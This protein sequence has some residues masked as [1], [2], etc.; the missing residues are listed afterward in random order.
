MLTTLYVA[1][2]AHRMN[3]SEFRSEQA[4]VPRDPPL[5]ARGEEQIHDLAAF[6]ARM[7]ADEQPQ[8]IICSPYTRCVRT[9]L[10]IH[11]KLGL[12]LCIEPGLAEWFGPVWPKDTGLHPSPRTA[13]HLVPQFPTI[14]TRW[15]P[16]LYPD[17]RGES[18]PGVHE[19]MR[20]L[21][22]RINERCSAWG[23]TLSLIHI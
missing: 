16:L 23:L 5:T 22:R 8:L 17:P 7:P 9:A 21:M 18:I 19:R 6:F 10:P 3:H 20:E 2:H 1:R 13:E 12:E 15:K 11:E 4:S 14:S